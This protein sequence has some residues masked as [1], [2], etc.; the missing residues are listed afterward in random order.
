MTIAITMCL[1]SK[2]QIST[3]SNKNIDVVAD[4]FFYRVEQDTI[5][6]SKPRQILGVISLKQGSMKKD[7]HKRIIHC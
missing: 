3:G 5:A 1:V 4:P 7:Q 2:H 6:M